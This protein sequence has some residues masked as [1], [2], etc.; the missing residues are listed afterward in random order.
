MELTGIYRVVLLVFYKYIGVLVINCDLVWS[1]TGDWLQYFSATLTGP[2]MITI[3][4]M[5]LFIKQVFFVTNKHRDDKQAHQGTSMSHIESMITSFFRW[6]KIWRNIYRRTGTGKIVLE[7]SSPKSVQLDINA[8][9]LSCTSPSLA[10]S[11]CEVYES[12]SLRSKYCPTTTCIWYCFW[13]STKTGKWTWEQLRDNSYSKTRQKSQ[14]G[15]K[16]RCRP[17]AAYWTSTGRRRRAVHSSGGW[18]SWLLSQPPSPQLPERDSSDSGL[19]GVGCRH[20]FVL[21]HS[22]AETQFRL[23]RS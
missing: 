23:A 6:S 17:I 16:E 8:S 10:H 20:R 18:R 1:R 15:H 9:F 3:Y 14:T 22:P 11:I 21:S 5:Y 19:S 7:V 13:T 4:W 12:V 2:N